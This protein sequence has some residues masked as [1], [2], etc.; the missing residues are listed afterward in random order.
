MGTQKM[1][2]EL[3]LT[4]QPKWRTN[5]SPLFGGEKRVQEKSNQTQSQK[6]PPEP[7]RP[8]GPDL[9]FEYFPQDSRSYL[10]SEFEARKKRRIQYSL[11]AFA[12][13]CELSPSALSEYLNSKLDFS[14]ERVLQV[15]KRLGL[16]QIHIEHWL[17]LIRMESSPSKADQE[18]AAVKVRARVNQTQGTIALDLFQ[19]ISDWYHFALLELIDLDECYQNPRTAAKA[20]GI[21]AKTVQESW[22]RLIHVGLAEKKSDGKYR[23]STLATFVGDDIPSAALRNYHAGLLSKALIAQEEQPIEKKEFTSIVF[24]LNQQDLKKIKDELYSFMVELTNKYS[25][26]KNKDSVYCLGAQLFDLLSETQK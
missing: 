7:S 6:S 17:D 25:Q 14:E 3:H 19:I 10:R 4:E 26:A 2:T 21:S 16:K 8:P 9:R 22:E 15:S 11:R 24:S 13:D 18:L 5:C 1:D 23:A 20:L 12:R